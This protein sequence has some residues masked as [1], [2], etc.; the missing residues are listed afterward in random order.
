MLHVFKY[1]LLHIISELYGNMVTVAL[2]H[3]FHDHH[4]DNIEGGEFNIGCP[5]VIC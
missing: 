4:V 3:V 5:L 1:Q 2:S